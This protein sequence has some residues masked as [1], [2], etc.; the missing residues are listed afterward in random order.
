LKTTTLQG[1]LALRGH[2]NCLCI[3]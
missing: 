2:F 1:Q 3:Y